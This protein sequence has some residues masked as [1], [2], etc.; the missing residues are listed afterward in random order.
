PM[1]G[2]AEFVMRCCPIEIKYL[3]FPAEYGLKKLNKP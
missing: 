3:I 1:L 2:G